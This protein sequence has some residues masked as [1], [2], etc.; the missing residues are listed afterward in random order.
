MPSLSSGRV[1]GFAARAGAGT[2]LAGGPGRVGWRI[3]R[4]EGCAVTRKH[5]TIT[6]GRSLFV[7]LFG[8][9][10]LTCSFVSPAFPATR[11]GG[12]PANAASTARGVS[13]PGTGLR[14]SRQHLRTMARRGCGLQPRWAVGAEHPATAGQGSTFF[15]AVPGSPTLVTPPAAGDVNGGETTGQISRRMPGTR[16]DRAPPALAFA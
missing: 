14:E 5:S 8:V 10:V 3:R 4:P 9:L 1:N 16:R 7:A 13:T 2:I 15:A 11:S 12:A 6:K